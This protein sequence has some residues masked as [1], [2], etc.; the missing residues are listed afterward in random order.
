MVSV[1]V[2]EVGRPGSTPARSVYISQKGGDLL[3]CYQLVPTS[4]DDWFNKGRVMCFHVYVIMDVKD[5]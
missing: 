1:P 3:A 5:P 4:A 2:C